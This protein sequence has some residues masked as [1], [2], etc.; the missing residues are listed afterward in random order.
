M[1]PLA[2]LSGIGAKLLAGGAVILG[3]ILALFGAKAS[4]RQQAVTE[5]RVADLEGDKAAEQD[6][7]KSDAAVHAAGAG[8]DA[9]A[10]LRREWKQ[11]GH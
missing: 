3:I 1:N 6:R 5:R 11:R 4:G 7:A 10:E 2:W 8:P 9:R